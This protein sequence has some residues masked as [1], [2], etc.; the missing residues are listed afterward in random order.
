M[1]RVLVVCNPIAQVND[2]GVT[3]L[4]SVL[5]AV[6]PVRNSRQR[7]AAAVAAP[8]RNSRVAGTVD[9]HDGDGRPSRMAGR[10]VGSVRVKGTRDGSKGGKLAAVGGRA[11]QS[12]EEP[13]A[14]GVPGAVDARLV[15]AV[16]VLNAVHEIRRKDLVTDAGRGIAGAFPVRLWSDMN[17][18]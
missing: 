15:D 9:L 11:G 14:V 16:V 1:A 2:R 10:T 12:A 3:A 7:T 6:N 13:G 18:C 8:I 17:P 5:P 4:V